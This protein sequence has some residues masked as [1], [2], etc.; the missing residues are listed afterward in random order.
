MNTKTGC[1][2][3]LL[4]ACLLSVS[5]SGFGQGIETEP[6]NSCLAAQ[7][8]GSPALPFSIPGSLDT[9]GDVFDIDY[10]RFTGTPGSPVQ[11]DHQGASAGFGTL[12][13]PLLGLFDSDCNLIAVN[14]DAGSLDSRL[15]FAVPADGVV[16]LAATSYPDFGFTGSGE[17]SYL[18]SLSPVAR[19]DSIGGRLIS[20]SDGSPLP[21]DS[22]PFA[23]VQLL[24]CIDGACFE[25]VN[26]QNTD[27]DGSF[28]FNADFNAGPLLVG[29]YQLQ[30]FAN[31]FEF[32][33]TDTFDLGE[34]QSLDLGDIAMTPLRVI[35][36]V[37]GRIV[38]AISGAPLSGFEPPFAVATLER[39][40]DFG[41]FGQIGLQADEQGRFSFDGQT[42]GLAPGIFRISVSAD[43]YE[44]AVTGQFSA[45]E[46]EDVNVGDIGVAP[47][48]LQFG[49]VQGCALPPGGG[50]CDYSIEIR[51][52]GAE[53]FR[54]EAWS[55][56]EFFSSEYPSRPSRFQVGRGGAQHP[57]AERVNLRPGEH[58]VLSFQLF[59]P[60][61]VPEN[62]T[63]CA[64]ATVGSNPQPQFNN[65]G[66]RFVFCALTTDGEFE[67]MS[68]K[69][70]RKK[71][72]RLKDQ[73][74]P[75]RSG[76]IALSR[77]ARGESRRTH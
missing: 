54:G 53:R 62:S 40:D 52:R 3:G 47:F 37:S 23:T 22:P 27:S 2:K 14:D 6:N 13:D 41:C 46:F 67:L 64:T 44:T 49:T 71:F 77:S 8:L 50:L 26:S 63:I 29:T 5:S 30:I 34:G 45:A 1:L 73:Q 56:V 60:G 7:D 25:F 36:L 16:V 24:R 4:I 76:E 10:F 19:G 17:G 42:Y 68:P 65:Q 15:I 32:L 31:G 74:M 18:L 38:D 28:I 39:C 55:T 75:N 58:T 69:E 21:G 70:G 12:Q 9:L 72:R 33:T 35:G 61:S 66:D 59:V 11:A 48:P 43:D 51:N 20:G 57:L